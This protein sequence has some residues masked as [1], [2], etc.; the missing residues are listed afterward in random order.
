[1]MGIAHLSLVTAD[2]IS[3]RRRLHHRQEAVAEPLAD[4][5]SGQYAENWWRYCRHQ[6]PYAE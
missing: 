2:T 1:M 6:R 5:D 3:I 4:G